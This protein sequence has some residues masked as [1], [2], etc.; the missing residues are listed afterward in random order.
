MPVR[1]HTLPD[2]V[3]SHHTGGDDA[4][5]QQWGAAL[6]GA[7]YYRSRGKGP[8]CFLM[9]SRPPS[10]A[11]SP[12]Q[13][14]L[15]LFVTGVML[16]D[17]GC[18]PCDREYLPTYPLLLRRRR[19]PVAAGPDP[20][21]QIATGEPPGCPDCLEHHKINTCGVL[22]ILN[23]DAT[24]SDCCSDMEES[25]GPDSEDPDPYGL[26][27]WVRESEHT[28]E[29]LLAAVTSVNVP[30]ACN[31]LYEDWEPYYNADPKLKVLFDWGIKKRI[32][33]G[34]YRWHEPQWGHPHIRVEGKAVVP[35]AILDKVIAAV[36]SFAHPGLPKTLELFKRQY[37][38]RDM[39][40]KEL[41]E[42]VEEV[43]GPCV[44]CAQTKARRGPH[45][46]SCEPQPMPSY[47]FASVAMDFVTLPEAKHPETGAKVDY[48]LVIVCRLTG[49]ILAI[50]CRK[51]GL[52]SRKAAGLFLHHCA[53]FMGIP[54]EIHSDN[55]TNVS[56][57]FFDALCGL[58]GISQARSIIYRPQ[59][60]GRA[61]RAVQSIVNSLRQ[62]LVLRKM[63]WV[64]ALPFALWGL[65]DLPGAVAPYSPHRLVFGRDPIGFGEVPPLT[66]DT[67]IED[68]TEYFTRIGKERQLVHDKLTAI[69]DREYRK[70]IAKC[71]VA[72]FKEGDRVWVRNRTDQPGL[73]PKLDRIWQGPA[74]ILRQISP[75]TFLVNLNGKE[76]ALS[77][78]RLKPFL[79]RRDGVNPP[80]HHYSER[81]DLHDDSYVIEDV[82]AH[83]YR[84]KVRGKAKKSKYPFAGGKPWWRIKYRGFDR[85]EWHDVTAFLHDINKDWL[86]Y[87]RRNHITVSTDSLGQIKTSLDSLICCRDVQPEGLYKLSCLSSA[88]GLNHRDFALPDVRLELP[89][90]AASSS[91]WQWALNQVTSR[92]PSPF[93]LFSSP[94]VPH[95]LLI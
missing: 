29:A 93:S 7:P 12:P 15:F 38:V 60:N 6:L 66:T 19:A 36:H 40:D 52:T 14:S 5:L 16:G 28:P 75:S 63:E 23:Q 9:I 32:E 69:H 25:V 91:G 13:Q 92:L 8:E 87:N 37:H 51:E 55:Q 59:S 49:Y 94:E 61:E 50:P 4:L 26:P 10:S 20:V 77:V 39:S 74:E 88:L 57:E 24:E 2:V 11:D 79:P 34:T 89:A 83:E 48:A 44:V 62:Y 82:L 95:D 35:I 17:Q 67:G 46:D 47:P 54:R 18:F 76:V 1:G 84:G 73:H 86:D 81:Q 71:P 78:E 58:A 90:P 22:G 72:R 53:F 68:A 21:V 30:P 70:F 43:V 3:T 42:R 65:N 56:S 85:P 31:I 80:L 64:Y 33:Y 41:E 45:P 27:T